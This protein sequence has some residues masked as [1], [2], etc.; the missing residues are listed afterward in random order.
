[1]TETKSIGTE[2]KTQLDNMA[3]FFQGYAN[4]NETNFQL[5]ASKKRALLQSLVFTSCYRPKSRVAYIGDEFPV[6]ILHALKFSTINYQTIAGVF[7]KGKNLRRF[8]SKADSLY[9]SKDI[10]S[11][12]RGAIGLALENCIPTPNIIIGN[13]SP[14]IGSSKL[15]NILYKMYNSYYFRIDTPIIYD[16]ISV[17]YLADQFRDMTEYIAEK[18]DPSFNEDVLKESIVYSND[19][20][21]LYNK[22]ADLCKDHQLPEIQRELYEL[23][24]SNKWGEKSLVE[25]CSLLYEEALE[26]I[27]TEKKNKKK[28]LLWYGPVPVYVDSL[29]ESI[30]KKVDIIFYTSLMSAN[31]ILLDENDTYRSLARRAL[32]HSWD[33]FMK[34]DNIIEVCGQYNIDGIILQNSWGCRNLNST[35]RIVRQCTEKTNVKYLLIDSDFVDKDKFSENQVKNRIDAFIESINF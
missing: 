20:K 23:I 3:G 13:S 19:A 25:I 12:I 1:M 27:K 26:C 14:C 35:N 16:D 32:L 22:V 28:R 17:D 30:G 33:P 18:Y 4:D 15:S 24:V 11:N 7:S 31:R 10:C 8:F 2:R 9:I 21:Q 6:E 29:L 5:K 34:C